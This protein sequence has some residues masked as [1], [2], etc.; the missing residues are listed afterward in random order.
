M[1]I[2][3]AFSISAQAAK[4]TA[5]FAGG[6]FWGI[7]AVF[8]HVKGVTDAVSGYAGGTKAT[9]NYED[10]ISG[11]TSHAESVLV[12]YDD[13]KVSYTQLLSV[14][15]AVAHDPTQLNRQGP[16]SGKQYRSAIFY[17]GAEQ[18]KLALAY[19]DAITKS[20]ALSKPVVTEVA[21]LIKFFPAEEYHQNYMAKNPDQP[22]IVVNDKP[23]IA[24]LKQK[25][26]E[27][28]KEK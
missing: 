15:F 16:D 26:P 1:L 2:F 12:T 18:K 11:Q 8:E 13:A 21:A 10:V 20:K 22:Y 5:V 14:F 4:Q 23:K 17:S 19:I 3:A 6:C 27:L 28:Y 9:A 7:E 24:A 25:F